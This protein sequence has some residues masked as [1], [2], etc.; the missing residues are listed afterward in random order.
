MRWAWE[1]PAVVASVLH[2]N[3]AE[4]CSTRW[5][6]PPE[7]SIVGFDGSELNLKATLVPTLQAN[8][9][10]LIFRALGRIREV[11]DEDVKGPVGKTFRERL[12]RGG[13][14]S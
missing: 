8:Y 4:V 1:L 5:V 13:F 7:L 14:K 10:L 11:L 9:K 12:A 2:L 6:I 3:L